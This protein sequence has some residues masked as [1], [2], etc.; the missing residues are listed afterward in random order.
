MELNAGGIK[1]VEIADNNLGD[2]DLESLV[3]AL[4]SKQKMQLERRQ[5]S[6]GQ[7]QMSYLNIRGNRVNRSTVQSLSKFVRQVDTN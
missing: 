4:S 1:H 7:H 3:Q 2:E 5:V 6:Q